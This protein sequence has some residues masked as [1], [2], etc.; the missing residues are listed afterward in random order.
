MLRGSLARQ[1]GLITTIPMIF[2][3]GP[4]VGY[5]IGSWI[6]KHYAVGS[7]G[8][9]FFSLFGF[10]ASIKQ[11]IVIIKQLNKEQSEEDNKNS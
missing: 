8:T 9:I 11:V 7:W 5:A 1:V 10:V 2:V 6:D 3:A 4:L